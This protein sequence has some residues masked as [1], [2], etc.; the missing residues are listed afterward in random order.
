M[1]V[2]VAVQ[3]S[4]SVRDSVKDELPMMPFPDSYKLSS[5]QLLTIII[6]DMKAM[7]MKKM[8]T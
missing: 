1:G 3:C 6:S 4:I 5:R 2:V 8:M 7:A